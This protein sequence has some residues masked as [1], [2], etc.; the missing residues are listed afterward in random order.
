MQVKINPTFKNLIPP[1]SQDERKQLEQLLIAEGIR[2]ALIIAQYP[3]EDGEEQRYLADGH[4]RKEIAEAHGLTY[5]TTVKEFESEDAVKIWMIDNQKGRR[6][7]ND[8]WRYELAQ[9]KEEIL[10]RKGREKQK[11]TL[12]QGQTL[13]VLSTIDKTEK[14]HN[15]R[16]EVAKELGWSTGKVAQAQQ[17]AKKAP[18]EV[19]EKL[20]QGEISINQAYQEVSGRK[21]HVSNN[22]GNNE[23]YTPIK[24]IESARVVMGSID[25][26]PA[27][28]LIANKSIRAQTIYT[29]DDDG[30]SKKWHGNIWMNPPYAQPLINQFCEKI[31]SEDF[32]QA[33]TLV[34]NATETAWGNIL[35]SKADAVCFVK[36]RIKFVAPDG[37]LGD[38]PLQGQ[39]IVYIG[40]NSEK[41]I[42]E[43]KSYG[44]CLKAK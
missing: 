2:D 38:S 27:S 36:G 12:M 21:A 32:D 1:L 18:D 3:D 16:E 31:V 15:T 33:I 41:F 13:P 5:Q 37:S 26:D 23:W 17:V 30:L 35:L 14:P 42:S 44:V 11:E 8:W 40:G 9:V 7:I 4:N 20:R 43:F 28:S 29:K 22:S 6:N 34:N 25:L 10:K 24:Y 39:M 19:K